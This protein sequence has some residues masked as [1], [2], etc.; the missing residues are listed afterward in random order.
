[1]DPP[2]T[3]AEKGQLCIYAAEN[4]CDLVYTQGDTNEAIRK[5]SALQDHGKE[6]Q[7]GAETAT[8]ELKAERKEL[9]EEMARLNAEKQKY[10]ATVANLKAEKQRVEANYAGQ[11]QILSNAESDLRSAESRLRDAEHD[12][13]RA[14]EKEK[15]VKVAAITTG[16]VVGL[17]TFGLGGAIAGTAVGAGIGELI[18]D[19]EG[20][21]SSAK[22]DR[23]RKINDIERITGEKKRIYDSLSQYPAQINDYSRRISTNE[24]RAKG[25]HNEISIIKKKIAIEEEAAHIWELFTLASEHATERSQRLEEVVR[26]AR[27]KQ[28]IKILRSDGSITIANSFMEAWKELAKQGQ[29]MLQ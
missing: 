25:K 21:V 24:E 19:S 7:K 26:R 2:L 28:N 23:A 18:N 17:F 4:V 12:L 27:E 29:I 3:V 9:E 6:L 15:D 13:K 14:R 5:L 16:V 22:S 1:M 11:Q 8:S 10:E 20:R